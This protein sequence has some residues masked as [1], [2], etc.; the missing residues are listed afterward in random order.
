MVSNN[1]KKSNRNAAIV[2]LYTALPTWH[3]AADISRLMFRYLPF[4]KKHLF[5][6]VDSNKLEKYKGVTNLNIHYNSPIFKL[7]FLFL[8]IFKLIKFFK[9]KKKK[10]IIIEG[11]SWCLFSYIIIKCLKIFIKNI[12]IIYHSHNVEYEVRKLKNSKFILYLTKIFEKKVLQLS[13]I[14]TAVSILDKKLFKKLYN[15]DVI[16]LANGIEKVNLKNF[17]SKLKLPKKFI[18]FPG[19]YT[20]YPNKIAIDEIMNFHLKFFI[21]KFPD[22]YFIFSGEGLPLKYSKNEAVKYFGI[23]GEKDYFHVLNKCDLVFMPLKNAPGTKLK[24]L[25]SLAMRRTILSTKYAFKGISI[26]KQSNIFIYKNKKEV[27]KL[28]SYIITNK[29]KIK[30]KDNV[31]IKKLYFENIIK[32]FANK[33]LHG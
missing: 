1:K 8:L 6:F 5:Q 29:K 28:L 32:D 19:S 17:N 7:L 20:Y 30:V 26:N 31:N 33:H 2:C 27:I 3:G 9:N 14:S 24:T 15:I 10:I 12:K 13:N 11:A 21:K 25:Q 4:K 22:Y 23:L 16:I 18:F